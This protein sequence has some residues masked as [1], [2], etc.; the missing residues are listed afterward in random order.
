[1]SESQRPAQRSPA[2][3]ERDIDRTRVELA[4][5]LDEIERR[6]NARY[7]VEKGF[8][9]LKDS[10]VGGAAADRALAAVRANPVPFALFGIGTAWLL[11]ANTKAGS[12]AA[13]KAGAMASDMAGRVGIG[14]AAAE[15]PLGHTGNAMVDDADRQTS[16]GWVHQVSGM[17]QGA[18]RTVRDSGGAMI[19]R[20]GAYAGDGAGRVAD[21][22]SGTTQRH[23]LLAGAIGVMA[24]ALIASLLP[25][26]RRED[27][28]I[29]DTRDKLW[30]RGEE[31]GQEAVAR[32][33]DAAARA[34]NRAVDAATDAASETL[35]EAIRDEIAKPATR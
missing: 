28:W 15:Q 3:I 19:N 35:K 21:G 22:L 18:L 12:Y 25:L 29:G 27:E 23:P 31:L 17:A 24:G 5:T 2:G 10:F 7:L 26:S 8:D 20:A 4:R 6:L 13:G 30:E 32:A 9:M 34:A 14:S 1:M 33:R 16:N 11:A